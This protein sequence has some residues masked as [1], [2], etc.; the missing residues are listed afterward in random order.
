MPVQFLAHADGVHA[1]N[2]LRSDR[3]H[4]KGLS[5]FGAEGRGAAPDG[6]WQRKAADLLD[7]V[8]RLN[9]NALRLPLAVDNVL[10][11]PPI[12]KWILTANTDLQPFRHLSLLEKLVQLAA[13]RG[14]LVMLDMHRLR[15]AIWPTAH[16]LWH[17]SDM[18]SSRL[19]EAWRRLARR[20]CRHWNVFAADLFNEPWGA[21]WGDGNAQRDWALFAERLGNI[22]LHECPRWLIFVEGIGAGSSDAFCDLCFWGENLIPLY[23]KSLPQLSIP[24][25]LVLSPHLYGPGTDSRMYYF[26]R[27]AFPEFPEN[28]PAIWSHHFLAPAHVAGSALVV[29]EWGGHYVGADEAWQDKLKAFLLEHE[30]SSF[31]WA[32]NPNS[33]DTGGIILDGEC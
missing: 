17:D 29:G 8:A 5:W 13:A 23:N 1:S 32:L 10:N 33:G 6:L 27:T 7:V 3:F 2:M 22:I 18:P 19:E 16:G 24:G 12:N 31:Y 25:R 26:N 14:L 9:F 28:M 21:T 20:F 15:A 4:L 30:L 11:D